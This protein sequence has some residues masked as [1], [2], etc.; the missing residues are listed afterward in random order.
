[1]YALIMAGGFNTTDY[2]FNT[3]QIVFPLIELI[4]INFNDTDNWGLYSQPSSFPPQWIDMIQTFQFNRSV[5]IDG[6]KIYVETLQS[7]DGTFDVYLRQN[8]NGTNLTSQ[9]F[10][11]SVGWNDI[12]FNQPYNI[13]ADTDYLFY[14]KSNRDLNQNLV[15]AIDYDGSYPSGNCYFVQG[16]ADYLVGTC[17]TIE[18]YPATDTSD[19]VM[20][21]TY[22]ELPEQICT[23]DWSC[24]GY[25][26][27]IEPMVNAS[28]NSVTDLNTCGE[29][30]GGNYSEF[31]PQACSYPSTNQTYVPSH[32]SSDIAGVVVDFGVEYGIEI[33]KFVGII[34]IVGL[35]IWLMGV[36]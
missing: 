21:I 8:I 25:E 6:V 24:T 23:P 11:L 30:Y 3:Y 35:G 5:E 7:L 22:F 36:L 4:G 31:T 2:N 34:A 9:S 20:K 1:M 13:S 12:N 28:C 16:E 19:I 27:C 33:I 29:V 17:N 26:T 32:A 14:F 10:N 18:N 15:F